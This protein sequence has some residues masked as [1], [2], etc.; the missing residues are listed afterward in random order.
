[1]DDAAELMPVNLRV[2]R[3]RRGLR[4]TRERLQVIAAHFDGNGIERRKL[5]FHAT[6]LG[7]E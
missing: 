7:F 2:V 1:L 4:K 6:A 3:N 5:A